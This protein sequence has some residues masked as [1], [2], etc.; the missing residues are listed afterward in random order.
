MGGD[1]T[2]ERESAEE[3][4]RKMVAIWQK[5]T[6]MQLS[7]VS[8]I[9]EK[10][11]FFFVQPNQY[12]KGSK[13]LSDEEKDIAIDKDVSEKRNEQMIILKKG[14]SELEKTGAPIFDLTGIFVDTKESVYI[15]S[16]CHFNSLGNHI[17]AEEIVRK[18][19]Q[20]YAK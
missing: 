7:V 15:D 1:R 8:E 14:F 2:K 18:I 20:H 6:M 9:A 19:Q 17:M 10:P 16:C 5:Y 4:T 12:L 13:L 11:I 3:I